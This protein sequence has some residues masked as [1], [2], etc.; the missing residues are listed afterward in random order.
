MRSVHSLLHQQAQNSQSYTN[1][2]PAL[3][4]TS[5]MNGQSHNTDAATTNQ[6]IVSA[7]PGVHVNRRFQGVRRPKEPKLE[8]EEG[9]SSAKVIQLS[10]Q[11]EHPEAKVSVIGL[12]GNTEVDEF[13]RL[14]Y[15]LYVCFL[16]CFLKL[17]LMVL[18]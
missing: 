10:M 1:S 17:C 4:N 2:H 15:M 7:S 11:E 8:M 18:C 13:L 6:S 14:V 3:A 9:P 5:Y 12:D 16:V